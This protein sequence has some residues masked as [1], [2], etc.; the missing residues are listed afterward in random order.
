MSRP[1]FAPVAPL[2]VFLVIL[3]AVLL[4]TFTERRP[5]EPPSMSDDEKELSETVRP[6]LPLFVKTTQPAD[7]PAATQPMTMLG[8]IEKVAIPISP[9]KEILAPARIDTGAAMSSLDARELKTNRGTR[10]AE[11]K[12]PDIMGGQRLVRHIITW[13][14]VRSSN[15]ESE[16][17][18]VIQ[19]EIRIG[20]RT[21]TTEVT[22]TDRSK[23]DFPLLIGRNTLSGLF[24][25]DVTRANLAPP[26]GSG[27]SAKPAADAPIPQ[28]S[29]PR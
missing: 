3:G 4:L 28:E 16:K 22:L 20:H 13:Q 27:V 19:M 1:S 11:F 21:V 5:S 26:D 29:P 8:A 25:V 2:L 18:P 12:L 23:M 6:T 15:G 7:L 24:L 17:R 9:D 10:V 14:M